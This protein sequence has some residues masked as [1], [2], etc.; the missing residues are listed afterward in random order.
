[1]MIAIGLLLLRLTL[2]LIFLLHGAQKLF[3]V[4]GGH[5]LA[6][7]T[8]FMSMLG[9]HPAKWWATIAAWGEFVG[10]LLLV[11]GLFTPLAALL[12]IAAML[13]AIMKVHASKGFWNSQ[14]GYEYN[15]VLSALATVLGLVGAGAFSLDAV[16]GLGGL[17][18][19]LFLL[20]LPLVIL[21]AVVVQRPVSAWFQKQWHSSHA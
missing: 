11:L 19:T 8:Q 21:L 17:S 13:V 16:L 2:G 14:G 1:M 4:F 3:G 12:I 7:T 10:G 20:G 9:L 5:G 18:P 6:G 15:L